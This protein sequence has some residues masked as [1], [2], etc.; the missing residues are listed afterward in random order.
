M[1]QGVN[2]CGGEIFHTLTDPGPPS[3]PYNWYRVSFL[4]VKQFGCGI[5]HTFPSSTEVKERVELYLY[6]P[7]GY[8]GLF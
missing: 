1:V 3:L 6:S 5:N 7:L 2:P 8:H 4:G